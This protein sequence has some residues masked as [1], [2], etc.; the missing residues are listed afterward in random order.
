MRELQIMNQESPIK[1]M[2]KRPK[3]WIQI[4]PIYYQEEKGLIIDYNGLIVWFMIIIGIII[5]I[6]LW[7]FNLSRW[8]VG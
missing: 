4:L 3:T 2:I 1:F 5:N 7:R 8:K 6:Y